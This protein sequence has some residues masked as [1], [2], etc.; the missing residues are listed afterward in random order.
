MRS[1]EQRLA[2]AIE[3]DDVATVRALLTQGADPNARDADLGQSMVE[4]AMAVESQG[5]LRAL[6]EFG[7]SLEARTGQALLHR[8]VASGDEP[9][10]LRALLELT[11]DV[12]APDQRGWTPLHL[13]AAYGYASSVRLLLEAGADP[14]SATA[15]GLTPAD[16]AATNGHHR[17]AEE[18]RKRP[19]LA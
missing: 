7:A 8:V 3:H 2:E 4:L 12:N 11:A 14:T 19:D 9:V 10:M 5:A 15:D 13:A 18:L 16:L 1:E 6:V 17:L